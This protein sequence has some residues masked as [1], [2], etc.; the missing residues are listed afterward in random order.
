LSAEGNLAEES[1]IKYGSDVQKVN[2]VGETIDN[3]I[4][5]DGR[6]KKNGPSHSEPNH[7]LNK[8]IG[9]VFGCWPMSGAVKINEPDDIQC[10]NDQDEI[11]VEAS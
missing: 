1:H 9:D 10:E 8:K 5:K 2:D 6:E 11:E 4:A 7:L 3:I